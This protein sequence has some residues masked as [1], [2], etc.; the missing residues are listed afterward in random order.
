MADW[1]ANSNFGG[2]GRRE[3][4]VRAAREAAP[5]AEGPRAERFGPFHPE[6][7]QP[8]RAASAALAEYNAAQDGP[9]A[10]ARVAVWAAGGLVSLALVAGVGI[11]GYKLV[12]REVMGLPVVVAEEGPMR[13]LPADPEGEVV[14][15][16]GLAVN[17][18]PA[19]GIAAP[20]S[21]VLMLAPQTPGL[22]EEDLEVAQTTAEADEV[23]PAEIVAPD[24]AAPVATAALA[25][26]AVTADAL[27]P[28]PAPAAAPVPAVAAVAAL[29]TQLVAS[30]HPMTTDEV[31]AF[32]D[33]ITGQAAL[34]APLAPAEATPAAAPA[35]APEAAP[36]VAAEGGA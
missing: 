35:P 20:P 27:A 28:A 3:P 11:W 14:P 32:A 13:V 8:P 17:A 24:A 2:M 29:T 36:L 6:D 18:I 12:W 16:Q 1:T 21:D 10:K 22:A 23:M 19:A 4:V 15:Q 30:D 34:L 26:V 33:R 25:P 31:L 9:L 7:A 5:R